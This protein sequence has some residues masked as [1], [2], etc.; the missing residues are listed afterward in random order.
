[1]S[2]GREFDLICLR[3]SLDTLERLRGGWRPSK[4]LLSRGRNADHWKINREEGAM[5]YQLVAISSEPPVRTSIIIIATVLAF[6]PAAHWGLL[7]ADRWIVLGEP[8]AMAP[9][10]DPADVTRCAETWLRSE[11]RLEA[12][13]WPPSLTLAS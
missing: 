9:P 3:H 12:K 11:M 2:Y 5:P 7:F 4:R 13:H 6:D 10:I 1:M 8:F